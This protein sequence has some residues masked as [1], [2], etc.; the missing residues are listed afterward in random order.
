METKKE[1]YPYFILKIEALSDFERQDS[2]SFIP[3]KK[4]IRKA[5]ITLKYGES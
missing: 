4:A 3:Y 1:I 5:L 2:V